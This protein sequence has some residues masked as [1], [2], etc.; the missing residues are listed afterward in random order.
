MEKFGEV[1]IVFCQIN[2]Q[3][4]RKN[5]GKLNACSVIF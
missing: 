4:L 5:L 3:N 2:N 1:I